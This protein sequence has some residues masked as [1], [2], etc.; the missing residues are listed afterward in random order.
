M[1]NL[2]SVGLMVWLPEENG[3]TLSLLHRRWW[4]PTENGHAR[5][6]LHIVD[7]NVMILIL[8]HIDEFQVV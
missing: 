2:R 4:L 3:L 7:V 8:L 6:P 5:F 1:P